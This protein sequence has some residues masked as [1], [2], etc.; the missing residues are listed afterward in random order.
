M[1]EL[2]FITG[3]FALASGLFL[4]LSALFILGRPSQPSGPL[5]LQPEITALQGRLVFLFAEKEL[6][7]ASPEALEFAGVPLN[8]NQTWDPLLDKLE[9]TVPGAQQR[10]QNLLATG[11]SFSLPDSG[12]QLVVGRM[13]GRL[14]RI[15]LIQ[16]PP[17]PLP[18]SLNAGP[19][20]LQSILD[21]SPMLIWRQDVNGKVDWSNHAYQVLDSRISKGQT[22]DQP[23]LPG[24][25]ARKGAARVAV[26][27]AGSEAPKWFEVH[28][29]PLAKT[30]SL[31]FAIQADPVVQAEDALRNFVQTL[32]M[33]FAHLPTG[34]AIFDRNRQLSLFNPALAELTTLD[35]GWLT[36]RPRLTEFLDRLRDQRH[37]PEPRDYKSWRHR[38]AALEKAAEDGTYMEHWPL[39]TGQTYRVTG[40]PHPEGA[41]A[42]LFEDITASIA[43]QRQFRAELDLGQ[44]VLDRLPG[45]LAVFSVTGD[46][47][48]SN[49]AFATLWGIEPR[50]MLSPPDLNAA[51][52][53]W[54]AACLP[55]PVWDRLVRFANRKRGR[56]VWISQLN[57]KAGRQLS[58]EVAPLAGGAFMCLFRQTAQAEACATREILELT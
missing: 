1:T 34:L 43:Q 35:P 4:A 52:E 19:D 37:L 51:L 22:G 5:V 40:R 27:L 21:K 31:H 42:F 57:L 20:F 26:S 36:G 32:T 10:L 39:P 56:Q 46:L 41:V 29:Y 9:A 55:S 33:T 50:E 6:I 3:I 11:Q 24:N 14:L 17:G 49:D 30:Q 16:A 28:S 54:R 7:E 2:G 25:V 13:Q 18:T 23:L 12:G 47:V 58:L 38:L 8:G 53:L 44:S 45:A 15:E 48:M